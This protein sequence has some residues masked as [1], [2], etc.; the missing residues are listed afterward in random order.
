MVFAQGGDLKAPGGNG[1]RC[2]IDGLGGRVPDIR[3]SCTRRDKSYPG[4]QHL[5]HLDPQILV[6]RI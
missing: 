5:A 1:T 3:G 2:W 4:A 6:T